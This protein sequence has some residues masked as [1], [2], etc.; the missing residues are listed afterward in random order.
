MTVNH[1]VA[2][3]LMASSVAIRQSPC[4]HGFALT[5]Q[6]VRILVRQP[7]MLQQL[8]E[9][10]DSL[11]KSDTSLFMFFRQ[12][13][14]QRLPFHLYVWLFIY[15]LVSDRNRRVLKEDYGFVLSNEKLLL[16]LPCLENIYGDCNAIGPEKRGGIESHHFHP[17]KK[18][19]VH[20]VCCQTKSSHPV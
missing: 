5:A 8:S 17:R 9:Q 15:S 3:C 13:L 18:L 14:C 10:S 6:S 7:L 16:S 20:A 12:P 11:S 4:R 19:Q 1:Q 2:I